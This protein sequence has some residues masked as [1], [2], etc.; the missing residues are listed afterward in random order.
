VTIPSSLPMHPDDGMPISPLEQ[1]RTASAW[2]KFRTTKTYD[3]AAAIPLI[4]W[5]GSSAVQQLPSIVH[6]IA[7]AK[8]S[9]VDLHF[10]VSTLA[11]LGAFILVV[12]ILIFVLLRG[13]AKAK[14][15]GLFPSIVAIAGT[16]FG[17]AVVWLPRIQL[18]FTLSMISLLLI[19]TG[20][21]F[22]AYSMLYLGRSFSIMPQARKLVTGGP[23]AIVRH[24]LYLGEGT[25]ILGMALQYLSPLALVIIGLQFAFQVQRMK[26]EECVLMK[27]FPE[28]RGYMARTARLIPG[29]Y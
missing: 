21:T 13:P 5:Y 14:T 6:K 24:P 25:A 10:I 29:V 26:N 20:V 18:G 23:Y 15:K 22:S 3:L 28:Y 17:V 12:T 8:A 19:L 9:D 2:Q 1:N 7:N 27:L 4:L 16:C 11:Q